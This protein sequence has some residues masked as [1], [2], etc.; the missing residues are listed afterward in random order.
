MSSSEEK[1]STKSKA[2]ALAAWEW[3][4]EA[5]W[6]QVLL[7]VGVVVGL[8]VAIPFVVQ[9]I[10]NAV[11][12]S[13]SNFYEAHRAKY[14]E[15]EKYIEG[16]DSSCVGTV[17]KGETSYSI[18]DSEEGFVVMY[19]KQNDSDCTNLQSRIE[20]WYNNFNKNYGKGN[21]KFYTID[22]GWYPS[23]ETK[24]K[25]YEGDTS[26]YENSYITLAQQQIVMDS[27]RDT[28]LSQDDTHKSSSV[29]EETFNTRLDTGKDAKT[30]ETPLFITY[31]RAIGSSSKFEMK[32]VIFDMI[33]SYSNTSDADVA[34]QML[35]IYNFQV[36]T[37][38]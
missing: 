18:S 30:L 38:K 24:N 25:D 19:Y 5:A 1:K 34:K 8:V 23:D 26:K 37:S 4:K 14:S 6:L 32:K 21:L 33:G 7:I 36:A 28:Y 27:V 31:T 11:N 15:V 35:D 13:N 10:V 16:K 12:S 3:F 2:H 17:G 22:C 9:A 29:T 20:T